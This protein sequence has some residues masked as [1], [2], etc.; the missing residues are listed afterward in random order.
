MTINPIIPIPVMAIICVCLLALKRKGIFPYI[1]QV[2]I[3]LLLFAINLRIQIPNDEMTVN[4]A[5]L[6]ANVIF[7]VDDTISM[8]GVDGP[9]GVT[10]LK[11]ASG[12]AAYIMDK[13][14]GADF[15]VISFHNN[16]QILSPWSS[17]IRFVKGTIA[18]IYPLATYSARG[19][20]LGVAKDSMLKMLKSGKE[21]GGYTIVFFLTDGEDNTDHEDYGFDEC[22]EY[23]NNGAV[24]AYGTTTGAEMYMRDSYTGEE[25]VVE[26][27]TYEDGYMPAITKMDPENIEFIAGELGVQSVTMGDTSKLDAIIEKSMAEIEVGYSEKVEYGFDETYYY[28]A[29]ALAIMMVIE[30][31]FTAKQIKSRK[32]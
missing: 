31:V 25:V 16:G 24:I 2:I 4:V 23:I 9:D 5:D 30:C 29:I 11:A 17:D 10:R 13:M 8:V 32:I 28:F 27:Y 15:S 12:D 3:I 22:A 18:S 7:V 20:N 21:R 14:V 6:K 19:T 1:R 26:T